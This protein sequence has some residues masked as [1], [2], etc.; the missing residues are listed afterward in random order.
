MFFLSRFGSVGSEK[1]KNSLPQWQPIHRRLMFNDSLT[2]CIAG[3]KGASERKSVLSSSMFCYCCYITSYYV[4]VT[5]NR[6]LCVTTLTM[7]VKRMNLK[8][9]KI[10][11][12]VFI[13]IKMV[14]VNGILYIKIYVY[15]RMLHYIHSV[16]YEYTELQSIIYLLFCL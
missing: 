1:K 15:I 11:Q 16:Q 10:N 5:Y 7:Q 12:L 8:L 6:N 2:E 9:N 13:T 4:Y 14:N 3:E